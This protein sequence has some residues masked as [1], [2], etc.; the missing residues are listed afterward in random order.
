[1]MAFTRSTHSLED[2]KVVL[3]ARSKTRVVAAF[4]VIEVLSCHM[5]YRNKTYILI[6]Q[7]KY[8]GV[9]AATRA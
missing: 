5:F 1:M 9:I 8:V 7:I 6:V 3:M 4:M 2:T